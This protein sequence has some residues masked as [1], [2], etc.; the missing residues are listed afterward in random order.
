MVI[1]NKAKTI[2][3]NFLIAIL[4]IAVYVFAPIPFLI[5]AEQDSKT[6][7]FY[8]QYATP[9]MVVGLIVL[10]LL[11]PMRQKSLTEKQKTVEDKVRWARRRIILIGATGGLLA[12]WLISLLIFLSEYL[13]DLPRGLYFSVLGA[14]IGFATLGSAEFGFHLGWIA[15]LITG[16]AIGAIFGIIMIILPICDIRKFGQTVVFGLMAGFIAFIVLFNP[17][18]RLGIEPGLVETL[19]VV[20]PDYSSIVIEYTLND[21]MTTLLAGSIIL[22]LIYGSI[23]GIFLHRLGRK[24]SI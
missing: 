6:A 24:Y 4:I 2:A 1:E 21:I 9:I 14:S 8:F 19:T 13:M 10:I 20:M 3:S 15:H 17:I 23:L 7:L 16:T 12:S 18:S 22:H 5:G 11:K